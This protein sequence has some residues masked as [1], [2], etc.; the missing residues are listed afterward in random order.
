MQFV[1]PGRSAACQTNRRARSEKAIEANVN[2]GNF[3]AAM[4]PIPAAATLPCASWPAAAPVRSA[5][6]MSLPASRQAISD[7]LLEFV[8]LFPV[9]INKS[10]LFAIA[11]DWNRTQTAAAADARRSSEFCLA[12]QLAD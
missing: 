4:L 3:F 8:H 7:I 1:A 6:P 2:D 11:S 9:K 10:L 12:S 5:D